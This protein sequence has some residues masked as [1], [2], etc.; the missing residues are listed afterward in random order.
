ILKFSESTY[1]PPSYISE[2]EKF[3]KQGDTILVSGMKTGSSKLKAR[4][5]E[6]V[7][8]HV[9]PAEV[10]LLIL[11]NILLNPAYDIYLLVGTSI[12]YRVQKMRQGKVTG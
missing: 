5:Q 12:Q 3:A 2:M 11:E 6:S 10:R 8:K 4:I 1:I 7:Y 9:Q